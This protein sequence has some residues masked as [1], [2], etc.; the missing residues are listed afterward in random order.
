MRQPNPVD[1]IELAVSVLHRIVESVGEDQWSAKTPCA[2]W[3]VR[4]AVNHTVGGMR[5]FAAELTGRSA[6]AEHESDWL[7]DSPLDAFDAAAAADLSAWRGPDALDRT[8]SISL[9]RLPGPLA[10]VIHLTELVVHGVDLAVSVGRPDLIDE[11]L[12]AGLLG[13]MRDMGGVDPYRVPGVFGPEVAV[14][15]T[16]AP[17]EQLAGFLGRDLAPFSGL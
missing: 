12:C 5:I 15:S 7:G 13:A 17:H 6:G 2:G 4:D 11:D 1:Q 9:G 10:A 14:G 8:V 16:A 3:D